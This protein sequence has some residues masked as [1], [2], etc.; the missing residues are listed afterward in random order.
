MRVWIGVL[1]MCAALAAQAAAVEAFS[2]Q[3]TVKGVRQ[4]TARFDAPMVA[5]GDPRAPSPFTVECPVAGSGKWLDERTWAYDFERDLPGATRCAFTLRAGLKDIAG[6]PLKP[7]TFRF[8]TGGPQ[9]VATRPW[10]GSSIDER[11][12]FLLAFD[13]RVKP[14]TLAAHTA[15]RVSGLADRIDV[16]VLQGAQRDAALAP[17]KAKN[18][19]L[20]R[21][22]FAPNADTVEVLRCKRPLPNEAEVSL[23]LEAGIEAGNGL[24]S[25]EPQTFDYRVRSAFRLRATCDKLNARAA[26]NPLTNLRVSL[27]GAIRRDDAVKIRLDGAGRS[28]QPAIE[29]ESPWVDALVFKGP[30]PEKAALTLS[31]PA[32]L[33]DDDGR[34]LAN[35]AQFPLAIRTDAYPPLAKFS[36][37]FGVLEAANP[38]LP[39]TLRNLETGADDRTPALP[40]KLA[41]VREGDVAMVI[42]SI[43]TLE[44]RASG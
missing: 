17:L 25:S 40:G 44:C 34:V 3:G 42:A 21:R 14:G 1:G 35:A 27:G 11:Q 26:C 24:A 16:E 36:S 9:A 12:T 29:D 31:V 37:H 5:L 7:E 13:A 33:K 38:V 8:D 43:T 6:Q 19:P 2:P 4:A 30:F 10:D 28:W 23:V 18:D 39:V 32:G 22:R 15:C 20:F 41:A